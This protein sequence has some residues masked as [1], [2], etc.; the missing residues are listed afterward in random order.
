[1]P[2]RIAILTRPI[3]QGTSG[4]GH[5]LAEM[6]SHVLDLNGGRFS[7]TLVHYEKNDRPIYRRAEELIVPRSPLAA[8]AALRRQRFD[9]VHYAPL[10]PYAPIW[11]VKAKKVGTVH[12]AEP[13][14]VPELYGPAH[15]FHAAVTK[16]WL[17]SRMDGLVTVSRTSR[18]F[19]AWKFGLPVQRFTV[20]YNGVGPGYRRLPESEARAPDRFGARR[21][22]VLHLSN[23][24]ERKNPAG[25]VGGFAAFRASPE[26]RGATLVLAGNRWGNPRV[27]ALAAEH[28]VER[29]V[30][31]PGFVSERDAV[32]L[33]NGASAFLFPSLA[34]GFGM[35]NLEAMAC[36]CPVVTSGVFAIPEIVG[37]AAL[38]VGDP[39]D[40][41]AIGDALRNLARD[42][43]LRESLIAKGLERARAFSWDES[44]RLL[45]GLYERLLA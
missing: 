43:G 9:L 20:C 17:A 40:R 5:H 12:G 41:T 21:P 2:P 33:L 16:P 15:R 6:V 14:L 3:D 24:S 4:S 42:P 36:G 13:Y 11:G 30:V 7:F 29:S 39:G 25:I 26:G 28:G 44:A 34:E 8:A 19:L 23:F 38:V 35:P 32:E 31:Y 45:L 1:V 18:D 37:D 27:R 10:S 22:Y